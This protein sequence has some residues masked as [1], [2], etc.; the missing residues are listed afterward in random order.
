M[1]YLKAN[2]FYLATLPIGYHIRRSCALPKTFYQD[3]RRERGGTKERNLLPVLLEQK[4]SFSPTHFFRGLYPSGHAVPVPVRPRAGLK[5]QGQVCT[6]SQGFP[7]SSL[8]Q[9]LSLICQR[10]YSQ[11]FSCS[12]THAHD[13]THHGSVG[14]ER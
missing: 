2:M 6:H 12:P 8:P 9:F 13:G 7:H 10:I 14:L 4:S 1:S 11:A 3:A 5:D